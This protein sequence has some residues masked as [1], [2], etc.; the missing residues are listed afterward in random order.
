[1]SRPSLVLGL[2]V[3]L[4]IVIFVRRQ[5]ASRAE[6]VDV[7]YEDGSMLSLDNGAPGAEPLLALA[8]EALRGAPPARS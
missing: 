5:N 2:L 7:Y 3:A 6:H 1:M 8:R 4:A